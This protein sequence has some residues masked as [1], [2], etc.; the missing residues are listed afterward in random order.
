MMM[1]MIM[2]GRDTKSDIHA[3]IASLAI[4]TSKDQQRAVPVNYKSRYFLATWKH[5]ELF[6][7][8]KKK[9]TNTH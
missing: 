8:K 7:K 4:T 9:K 2:M 3:F 5:S 1:M 6:K